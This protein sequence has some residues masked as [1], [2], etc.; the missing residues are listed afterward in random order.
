MIFSDL[1]VP[2]LK[3]TSI[4]NLKNSFA[5]DFL[6]NFYLPKNHKNIGLINPLIPGIND[7]QNEHVYLNGL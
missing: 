4:K 5:N 7:E 2:K 6:Y 1:F 3:F